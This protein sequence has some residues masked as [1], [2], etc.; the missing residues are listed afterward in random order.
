MLRNNNSYERISVFTFTSEYPPDPIAGIGAH[1]FELTSGLKRLGAQITILVPTLSAPAVSEDGG[2]RIH[3]ISL[4][5]ATSKTGGKD[6]VERIVG[7]NEYF[8]EY[9]KHLIDSGKVCPDIIH[10]HDW[11][12]FPAAYQLG[13]RFGIPVI[14]TVHMLN[15]PVSRWWG[16]TPHEQIIAIERL[17]C[18]E[19]DALIAVSHSMGKII[20]E[21]HNVSLQRIH[22]VHNG[23]D[24]RPFLKSTVSN[25]AVSQW[26]N[27]LCVKGSKVVLFAGRISP[28]KGISAMLES[29]AEIVEKDPHVR[30]LVVGDPG[31][32][33]PGGPVQFARHLKEVLFP[34][35]SER[36]WS[37]VL[38][39]W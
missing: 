6:D 9:A 36:L 4:R 20:A 7:A 21:T 2:A 3:R 29:A 22:V 19:S 13:R 16:W 30:Y 23:L 34:Q 28:Q 37:R 12:G 18:R 33:N 10:C 15:E 35:Y 26:K 5:E 31:G 25:Q 1:A 14:S 17:L 32:V 24:I 11:Y 8:A 38:I 27:S 39:I